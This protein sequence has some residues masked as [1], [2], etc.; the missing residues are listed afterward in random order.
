MNNSKKNKEFYDIFDKS[1]AKKALEYD[2]YSLLWFYKFQFESVFKDNHSFKAYS[3]VLSHNVQRLSFHYENSKLFLRLILSKLSKVKTLDNSSNKILIFSYT[4]YWDSYPHFKTNESFNKNKDAFVGDI[5]DALKRD[6]FDIVA[7]DQ[8]TSFFVNFKTYFEKLIYGSGLWRPIEYYLSFNNL[9]ITLNSFVSINAKWKKLK[10]EN[11]TFFNSNESNF[12]RCLLRYYDNLFRFKIF[13]PIIYLEM[14]KRAIDLE[15]PD[16]ILVPCGYCLL[17]RAAI[18]AGK[19]KGVPTIEIQHGAIDSNHSGYIFSKSKFPFEESRVKFPIPDK[20]AVYG[21]FYKELLMT[22]SAYS[23][24]NICVTG[25]PRYDLITSINKLYSKDEFFVKHGINIRSK[26]ILWTTQCHGFTMEENLAN[27]ETVFSAVSE[28]T[29]VTLV[30]KQHPREDDKYTKI[31]K[32]YFSK[33]GIKVLL[34]PKKSDTYEQLFVC[35]LLITKTSTTAMEAV[36]LNKPVIILNLSGEAD[37]VDYVKEGV[38]L[39][40]Y[41]QSQLKTTIEKLLNDDNLLKNNRHQFV[42]KYLYKVDG[43]STERIV[44]L[45]KDTISLKAHSKT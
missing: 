39:G 38:A 19:I 23:D 42:F 7:L 31:I 28:L 40:V 24:D 11:D 34:L 45:I 20:T 27:F 37:S 26:I 12:L 44:S 29:D 18:F 2:G 32:N 43:K 10:S 33:Y 25:Q 22:S 9:R 17:G 13:M 4:N 15:R 1:E 30:V 3:N 5:I 8:D 41:E 35:D 16:L 14:C 6:N 36:I 21:H